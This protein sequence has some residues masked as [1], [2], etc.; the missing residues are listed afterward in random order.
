MEIH[1]E[2]KEKLDTFYETKKIPNLIF[3]GSSSSGKITIVKNFINT[4]YNNNK[5]LIKTNV[6]MVNCSHGK[7]IKFIRDELKFFAK[8]NLNSSNTLLFK[9]IVLLNADNLTTDAQSALRRCIEQFS[10]TTRFFMVLENKYKLLQPILSRFC[11]IYVNEYIKDGK[12]YNLEKLKMEELENKLTDHDLLND[13]NNKMIELIDMKKNNE[14][15]L[16]ILNNYSQHFYENG[17]TC[18]DLINNYK[19]HNF[20]SEYDKSELLIIFDKIRTEFRFEKL[21]MLLILKFIFFRSK[22]DLK[23][24]TTI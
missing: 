22:D 13:L 11:E 16:T 14:L 2:I 7:G 12:I 21:L 3:H 20:D 17:I 10:H 8:S 24:I 9:T 19:Q 15:D 6:M 18:L 23:S 4:I 1:K 5:Q